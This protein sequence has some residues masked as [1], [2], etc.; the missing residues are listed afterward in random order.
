MYQNKGRC[1]RVQTCVYDYHRS[2]HRSFW[3]THL[4]G[5]PACSVICNLR[6]MLAGSYYVK[7]FYPISNKSKSCAAEEIVASVLLPYGLRFRDDGERKTVPSIQLVV[8]SFSLRNV[9]LEP[10]PHL[11]KTKSNRLWNSLFYSPELK[12]DKKLRYD[13][14]LLPIGFA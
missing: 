1:G 7:S 2:A 10:S 6:A 8:W 3:T 5:F 9:G 12:R 11:N 13:I 14:I 4:Y